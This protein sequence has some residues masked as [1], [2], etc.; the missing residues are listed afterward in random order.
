MDIDM[1]FGQIINNSIQGEIMLHLSDRL[2]CGIRAIKFIHLKF[3]IQFTMKGVGMKG[4]GMG[5]VNA[6]L[7]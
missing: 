7:V 4:H 5:G 2:V 1:E 3:G 6:L